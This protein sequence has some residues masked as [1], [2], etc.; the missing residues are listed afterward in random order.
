[1][2]N[3]LQRFATEVH[4]GEEFE[5][6]IGTASGITGTVSK[7]ICILFVNYNSSGY[8]GQPVINDCYVFAS[9]LKTIY[10][11]ECFFICNSTKNTASRILKTIV[12]QQDKDVVFYYSGHGTSVHDPHGDESDGRDEAFC[13]RDGIMIDDEFCDIVNRYMKCQKL[14][15]ITDACYSGTIYDVERIAPELKQ[16]MICISSCSDHQTSKQLDKNG[17]FTMQFWQCFDVSSG[18]FDLY[19]I[20]KRLDWFDQHIVTYPRDLKRIDF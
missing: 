19:K 7:K 16:R 3:N 13:F 12:S 8:L 11:Y 17:V 5:K 10:G 2:L 4:S 15:C 18:A 14:I 6:A 1:M 20:N 9:K